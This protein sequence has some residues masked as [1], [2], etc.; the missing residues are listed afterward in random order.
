MAAWGG[1]A[2]AP[3]RPAVLAVAAAAGEGGGSSSGGR[4]AG[5][6]L[7]ARPE[8]AFASDSMGDCRS[9]SCGKA[10]C[11]G[12][13]TGVLGPSCCSTA[14]LL[15]FA[16]QNDPAACSDAV[17]GGEAATAGGEAAAA[18]AC[19]TEIGVWPGPVVCVLCSACAEL[20]MRSPFTV[21]GG[22]LHSLVP[23]TGPCAVGPPLPRSWALPRHG[24]ASGTGRVAAA[25]APTPAEPE[26]EAEV[27]PEPLAS[28]SCDAGPD[29]APLPAP[30]PAPAEE[31]ASDAVEVAYSSRC[32]QS[33]ASTT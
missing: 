7:A 2:G 9:S 32:R 5:G 31:D 27:E 18:A 3:D 23:A 33:S 26:P 14:A 6:M 22:G 29:P 17:W 4:G 25:A 10:A 16:A 15:P 12:G 1:R 13:G 8:P 28:V 11:W 19:M 21:P 30:A 20:G 24:P